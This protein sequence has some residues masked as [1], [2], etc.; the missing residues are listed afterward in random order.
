MIENP[1][2]NSHESWR[3]KIVSVVLPVMNE[4]M[5]LQPFYDR[6]AGSVASLTEVDWEFIFVDDGSSDQSFHQMLELRKKDER[7]KAVRLSRNFGSHAAL[8][9][10]LS[11]ATGNAAVLMSV[12]LQDPPEAIR[13]F[14]AEWRKGAHVVWGTRRSRG[15]PWAKSLLANVFYRLCR[16]V[17][18]PNYPKGGMD[19]GLLDRR[20]IDVFLNIQERNSFLFAIILWMGFRQVYVSYERGVRAAGVSKW[21]FAKRLKSAMDLIISFS[22]FPIRMMTVLGVL[23]SSL[24]FLYALEII[25]EVIFGIRDPGWPSVMVAILFFSGLQLIMMG[26]LGEYIWR[27]ADQV[28]GRPRFIVMEEIGFESKPELSR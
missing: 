18:L 6:L 13:E 20:V 5:N 14:I 2:E 1:Q 16:K 10:G 4:E 24:S 17:A 28:K 19:C 25:V 7:V 3:R 23:V 12:D 22:Y 9:A 11:C 27:G 26:V 15:D 21:P 8:T